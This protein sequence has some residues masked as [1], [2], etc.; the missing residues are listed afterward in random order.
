MSERWR[1][2]GAVIFGYV[3]LSLLATWPLVL[4][5]N[6]HAPGSELWGIIRINADTSVNLWDLWWFR[7]ALV[8]L[9]QSPFQ[10]QYIFYPYGANLWFHTLAPLHGLLGLPLQS[11]LSLAATRNLLLLADLVGS[12][13]FSYLLARHLGIGR[14]AAFL[15]G[16]IYAFSPAIFAHLY[17]GHFELLSTLWL[18]AGLLL[19]LR[20]TDSTAP[21]WWEG[22]LLGLVFVGTAYTSQYYVIFG[23]E[24]LGLAAIIRWRR[25][26]RAAVL[27][28]LGVGAVVALLGIGPILWAFLGPDAPEPV[29]STTEDF[30]ANGGD[31]A[32]FLVPSFTHTFL[33]K[34]LKGLHDRVYLTPVDPDRRFLR[35]NPPQET[36]MFVGFSVLGLAVFALVRRRRAG[37]PVALPSAIALV[38]GI[39]ALGA[40]LKV[41]GIVTAL[42]LPAGL[43]AKLPLL[44]F[45]RAPGRHI[46]L[47]MLGMGILAGMGWQEIRRGAVRWGVLGLLA[48]EYTAVPLPLLSTEMPEVYHRLAHA[49][50]TFAILEIP[51]GMRDGLKSLGKQDNTQIL[52]QTVHGHPIVTGVVSRLD[53]KR[54]KAIRA[55][56][57][58]GTLLD[59]SRLTAEQLEED[60]TMGPAYFARWGIRAVLIH[61]QA[62]NGIEQRYLERV[63]PIHAREDYADGFQ[64]L[65]VGEQ[66]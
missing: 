31:L 66:P 24:L 15:A 58:I 63:L 11:V 46:V 61:P 21:R 9:H 43:L 39:L 60:R 8:D 51:L 23:V 38:F 49:P 37:A 7:H 20:L 18:P 55:T 2:G 42:P 57:V 4:H 10:C 50:G 1:H 47:V 40:H 14:A 54:W 5:F 59:P 29:R 35:V 64:L 22:T 12:G 30:D 32:A 26:A 56:P 33:A 28:A 44:E 65:W 45:A 62:R 13:A 17:V 27:K 19:F 52:A 16:A 34:P 36:T 25:T 41:F 48:L 53:A 3:A 6:T